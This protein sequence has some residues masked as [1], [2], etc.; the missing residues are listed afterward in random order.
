M[1]FHRIAETI[2]T[3]VMLLFLAVMVLG[4][5]VAISLVQQLQDLKV[6]FT[7][8]IVFMTG[9]GLVFFFIVR[10][11]VEKIRDYHRFSNN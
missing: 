6:G 10:M 2:F 1:S 8:Q 11:I 9:M 5:L 7:W 3:L 4:I